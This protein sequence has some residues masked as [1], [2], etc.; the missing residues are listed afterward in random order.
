MKDSF[1]RPQ[2]LNIINEIR[3]SEKCEKKNIG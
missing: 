1:Y 2:Y 3:N